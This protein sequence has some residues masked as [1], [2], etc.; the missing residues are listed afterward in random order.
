M[1]TL[2]D[3]AIDRIR[4]DVEAAEALIVECLFRP[5]EDGT[6]PDEKVRLDRL[7]RAFNAAP[8]QLQNT[9]ITCLMCRAAEAPR[10]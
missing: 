6:A 2:S 1:T 5:T 7:M 8:G 4:A 10:R 3:Y 9:L